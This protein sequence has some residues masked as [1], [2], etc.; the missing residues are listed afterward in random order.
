M[1]V[2]W[3]KVD[4]PYEWRPESGSIWV[5]HT[6]FAVWIVKG[7]ERLER[8]RNWLRAAVNGSAGND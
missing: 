4:D 8:A 1:K 7:L 6:V 3:S 5:G 2:L